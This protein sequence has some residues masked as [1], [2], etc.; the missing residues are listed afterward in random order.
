MTPPPRAY[1]GE[2]PTHAASPA[3]P[4]PRINQVKLRVYYSVGFVIFPE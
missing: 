4:L 1:S 2:P 3:G